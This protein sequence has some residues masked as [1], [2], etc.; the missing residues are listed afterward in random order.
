LAVEIPSVALHDSNISLDHEIDEF[1][2]ET[3]VSIAFM[4]GALEVRI[5]RRAQAAPLERGAR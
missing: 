2:S 5:G 1:D 4:D 3:F